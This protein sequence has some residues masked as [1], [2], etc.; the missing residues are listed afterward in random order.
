M[1]FETTRRVEFRD[2]DA[3]GIVHF[4]VFFTY[5]EQAEHELLR[6][7]GDSVMYTDDSLGGD[8]IGWPRV[9]ADCDYQSPVRF[10][11][12]LDVHVFLEKLGAKSVRYRHEF[13]VQSRA[14]AVGHVTA[15]CCRIDQDKQLQSLAIPDRLRQQLQTLV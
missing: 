6:S 8:I 10:E 15:V 14:V 11:D 12:V 4:S 9:A 5:M 3:A 7:L 1:P 2:T 13:Y